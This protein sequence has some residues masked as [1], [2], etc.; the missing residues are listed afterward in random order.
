MREYSLDIDEMLVKGIKPDARSIKNNG[1]LT[2]LR[3][4]EASDYGLRPLREM[5]DPFNG[6][7]SISW[8]YPQLFYGKHDVVLVNGEDEFYLVDTDLV[9]WQA[10][11]ISVVESDRG[12]PHGTSGTW[13]M[14]DAQ[15][16]W[17][18]TNGK[19]ML[20]NDLSDELNFGK[21]KYRLIKNININTGCYHRGRI[22]TGGIEHDHIWE[23]DWYDLVGEFQ[24]ELDDP[25]MTAFDDIDK[26]YVMWSSVGGGDFPLW[27]IKPELAVYGPLQ[28]FED[29]GYDLDNISR[30]MLVERLRRNEFGWM[31]MPWRGEILGLAP[32]SKGV[33]VLGAGGVSAMLL[34]GNTYGLEDLNL[35][36]GVASRGSYFSTGDQAIWIDR[37][38][39][40]WTISSQLE[41]E[42]LGY[43]HVLSELDFNNVIINHNSEDS[44]FYISDGNHSFL[45]TRNGLSR[46]DVLPTSAFFLDGGLVALA[47][48]T[49]NDEALIVSGVY[50]L[51][52][53]GL[54]TVTT[55]VVGS[56]G[57]GKI[58]VA[59]DYRYSSKEDY[60]RSPF[61]V[62]NKEGNAYVNITTLDFRV[63]VRSSDPSSFE[64]DFINVRYQIPD[65]RTIRGAYA[66]PASS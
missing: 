17:L 32:L 61:V 55:I 12:E 52:L 26:N 43:A 27:L 49:D 47:G 3:N 62:T 60:V 34:A 58:E 4:L 29:F 23:D 48:K 63:I 33:L 14:I 36:V 5:V 21:R 24:R 50:D 15:K 42:R 31:P 64:L 56:S 40:L 19:D 7:F 54:K 8:P 1:A 10:Q 41:V 30:T 25:I 39:T 38:G 66:S 20:V 65:K 13:E 44:T 51:N 45:L 46:V 18:L 37:E 35:S 6:T 28:N 22:L 11:L 16:F 57:G 9:P 59:V 2:D 53:R